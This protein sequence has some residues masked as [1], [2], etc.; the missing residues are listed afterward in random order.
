LR[1][2]EWITS[3]YRPDGAVAASKVPI[4]ARYGSRLSLNSYHP[5]RADFDTCTTG[6]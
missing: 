6:C 3:S 4:H 2:L 5:L 1:L